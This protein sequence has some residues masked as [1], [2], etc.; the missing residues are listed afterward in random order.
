MIKKKI[1]DSGF[2][3]LLTLVIISIILAIGLTLLQIT[4]KQ[5]SLSAIAR[6]SEIA[7]YAASTGLECMQYW[8][9]FPPV[10]ASLLKED[11][12]GAAYDPDEPI[13]LQCADSSPVSYEEVT[14]LIDDNIYGYKYSYNLSYD[15]LS[16][17]DDTCVEASIYLADL[18]EEAS[19]IEVDVSD[20]GEGLDQ[21]T[22]DGGTIC[23]TIFSRGYNR[24]C[25]EGLK[26]IFTVQR[27]LTIEY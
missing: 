22:C 17:T 27:E 9:S 18:R 1:N 23:T 5:L 25:G 16:T 20:M 2:A 13:Y 12:D 11:W 26:S 14:S 19:D 15:P 6:E 3:L 10:R 8:R 4:M 21:L 24:P 7:F